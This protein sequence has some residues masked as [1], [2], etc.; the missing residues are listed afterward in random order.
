MIL[1]HPPI[2]KRR[3]I[4]LTPLIDVI[5][6]L[7]MMEGSLCIVLTPF[8][9]NCTLKMVGI[10]IQSFEHIVTSPKLD[11]FLNPD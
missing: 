1:I 8:L 10:G 3:R 4:P 2:G 6:I 7:V 9:L 11:P 5:F